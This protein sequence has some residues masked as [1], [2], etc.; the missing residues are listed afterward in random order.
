MSSTARKNGIDDQVE[1]QWEVTSPSDSYVLTSA[2]EIAANL[3]RNLRIFTGVLG[4][5][6][7]LGPTPYA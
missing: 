5:Y 7:E 1:K 2:P 6:Y 4:H 3:R